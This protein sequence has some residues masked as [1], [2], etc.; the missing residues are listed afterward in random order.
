MASRCVGRT[1]GGCSM[2]RKPC[3]T[4][5]IAFPDTTTPEMVGMVTNGSCFKYCEVCGWYYETNNS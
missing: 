3:K 1:S 5:R 4:H 2:N